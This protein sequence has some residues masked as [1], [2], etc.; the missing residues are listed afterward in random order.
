MRNE[1][2]PHGPWTILSTA[3]VYRDRFVGVQLDQVVRP[4]GEP[5]Q[6]V[7]VQIKP[8]VCVLAIDEDEQVFLTSEFHYAVGRI[9]LEAV[10]GGIEPGEDPLL[11]A[12]R[13]LAEEIGLTARHWDLLTTIDPFTTIMTSP[14]RLYLARG[15]GT[16]PKDMEGTELIESVRLPLAAALEKI[17]TGEITHA[18]TCVALLMAARSKS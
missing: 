12:Q 9:S 11:T 17:W 8:G 15:L 18:P 6:H 16:C 3:E 4:D 5:G 14:T 7:V 13:E 1:P 10:S 2:R